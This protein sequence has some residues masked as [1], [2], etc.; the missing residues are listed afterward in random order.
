VCPEASDV[1]TKLSCYPTD[2]EEDDT[3]MLEKFVVTMY[4]RSSST[5]AV[6]D[7]RLELVGSLLPELQQLLFSTSDALH[8]RQP[9]FGVPA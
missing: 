9:G 2:V 4:D 1:F 5:V 6:E 7:A 3:V 8:I